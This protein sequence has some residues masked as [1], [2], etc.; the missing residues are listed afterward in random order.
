M[1]TVKRSPRKGEA[2]KEW[3]HT[4]TNYDHA[5]SRLKGYRNGAEYI[6][7]AA[8]VLRAGL[9]ANPEPAWQAQVKHWFIDKRQAAGL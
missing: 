1:L 3:R 2:F 9:R 4:A 5:A 8:E 7:L 6:R